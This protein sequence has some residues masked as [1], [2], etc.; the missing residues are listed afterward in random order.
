MELRTI[1]NKINEKFQNLDFLEKLIFW[2]IVCF[3]LPYI[4]NTFFYLFG[5]QNISIITWFELSS[6]LKK[7]IFK[8]WSIFSYSFFHSGFF[9]LFWN[10]VLLFYSGQIYLN[11]FPNKMLL[12]TYFIG[13]IFGGIIFIF[14][15]N[16]FPIFFNSQSSMI[17]SSA[18]VMAVLIFTCVYNPN[19]EIKILFFNIKLLY[20]GLFFVLFDI[21]QIP[22]GNAG[23]HFAHLGGSFVGFFYA[24][25]I[26]TGSDIF[27][28]FSSFIFN[29]FKKSKKKENK[30]INIEFNDLSKK[31]L[32][33]KKIDE[34]LDKISSSGYD[35]LSQKEKDFLFKNGEK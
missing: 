5:F 9:H 11:L 2:N 28:S 27:E 34:I 6:E 20:V 13:V 33:Q 4:F 24:Q 12:S 15:Y 32:K 17:G 35:S 29:I 21:I 30:I 18:G 1:F 7:I 22:Y 23:G 25:K 19:Y 16:I 31:D 3:V 26:K 8:P 14:C 10:M